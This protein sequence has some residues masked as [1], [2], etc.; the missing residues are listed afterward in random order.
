ME[1]RLQGAA[2]LDKQQLHEEIA[3]QLALPDYYGEN[4][5]AL[6]DVLSTWH[7]PLQIFVAESDRLVRQ[8]GDYG[9]SVLQLLQ[10]AEAENSAITVEFLTED[11][12]V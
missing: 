5:D 10:D 12:I 9:E 2:L 7:E 1:L 6:W 3:R 4:L 11:E 8:L